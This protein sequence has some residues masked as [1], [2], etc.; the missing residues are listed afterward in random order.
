MSTA[1]EKHADPV[2]Q[3]NWQKDDIDTNL[4]FFSVSSDGYVLSWTLVKVS[5]IA[6]TH[7]IH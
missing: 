5:H 3:I 2:W 1:E 7:T 4:V 6:I